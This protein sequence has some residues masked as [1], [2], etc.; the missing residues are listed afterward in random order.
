MLSKRTWA[1]M[2]AGVSLAVA[3]ELKSG[4]QPGDA[5]GA[6]ELRQFRAANAGLSAALSGG[7]KVSKSVKPNRAAKRMI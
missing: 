1:V 6:F 2:L 3:A 7:A 5:I 4:V